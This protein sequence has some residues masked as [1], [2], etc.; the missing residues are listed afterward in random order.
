MEESGMEPSKMVSVL[1][2]GAGTIVMW[3]CLVGCC[4]FGCNT[5]NLCGQG[6]TNSKPPFA[7]ITMNGMD[8]QRLAFVCKFEL[9]AKW[10]SCIGGIRLQIR[11]AGQVAIMD[12]THEQDLRS[13]THREQDLRSRTHCEQDLRS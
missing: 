6:L 5:I 9:P 4:C 8:V 7:L 11:V 1:Q 3:V 10:P 12:E 13:R 2:L